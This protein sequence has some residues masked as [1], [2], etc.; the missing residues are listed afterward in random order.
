MARYERDADKRL[1]K[2]GLFFFIYFGDAD[3]NVMSQ[4]ITGIHLLHICFENNVEV[5]L[6]E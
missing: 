2:G 5:T 4:N 3:D 6:N 1:S